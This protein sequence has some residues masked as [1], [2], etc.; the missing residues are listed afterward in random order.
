MILRMSSLF[1]RTLRDDPADAEDA[2]QDVFLS[3][4]KSAGRFD[5]A[6]SS[7]AGFVAMIASSSSELKRAS[8]GVSV[9]SSSCSS[10]LAWGKERCKI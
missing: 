2:V 7:E 5:P 1:L 9:I 6:R 10:I 4:W 8:S 3:L